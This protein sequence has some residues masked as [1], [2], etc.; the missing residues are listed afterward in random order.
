MWSCT[1]F[2]TPFWNFCVPFSVDASRLHLHRFHFHDLSFPGGF[3]AGIMWQ[4]VHQFLEIFEGLLW[5]KAQ[6]T[7]YR[8]C[9]VS[10]AETENVVNQERDKHSASLSGFWLE[11]LFLVP[12]TFTCGGAICGVELPSPEQSHFEGVKKACMW[13]LTESPITGW[14]TQFIP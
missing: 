1:S 6:S 4:R 13:A 10:D 9:K 12:W 7:L 8:E 11:E 5:Q 3:F 14:H 2:S